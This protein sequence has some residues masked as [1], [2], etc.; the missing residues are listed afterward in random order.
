LSFYC[1]NFLAKKC[2]SWGPENNEKGGKK[3][4]QKILEKRQEEGS[5]RITV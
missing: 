5:V 1:D 2:K 3:K 4:K